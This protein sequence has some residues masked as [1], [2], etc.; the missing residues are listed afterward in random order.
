MNRNVFNYLRRLIISHI[1]YH[2][3]EYAV[4]FNKYPHTG[5]GPGRIVLIVTNEV[6]DFSSY[7]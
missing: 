6:F 3:G 1:S 5:H 2:K 7:S 4:S